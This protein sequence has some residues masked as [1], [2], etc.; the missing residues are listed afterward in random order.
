MVNNAVAFAERASEAV[1]SVI[2]PDFSG[3]EVSLDLALNMAYEN[4]PGLLIVPRAEYFTGQ[5]GASSRVGVGHEAGL[6]GDLRFGNVTP[7]SLFGTDQAASI[8]GDESC[9]VG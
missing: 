8:S 3:G 7:F 1:A 5:H 6:G 2:E 4:R 9:R